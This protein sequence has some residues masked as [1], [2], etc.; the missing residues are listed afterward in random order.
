MFRFEINLAN[1]R[2]DIVLHVNPRVRDRVLVLNSAPAGNW[3]GEERKQLNFTTGDEFKL[4]IM[5]TEQ[6]F[7]VRSIRLLFLVIETIFNFR[8]PSTTNMLAILTIDYHSI[9]PN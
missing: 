4:I 5:V 9:L 6:A 2:G 8:L 7:K 1:N 3:G